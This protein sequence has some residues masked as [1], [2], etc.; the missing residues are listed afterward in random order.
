MLMLCVFHMC[1]PKH[2]MT[3]GWRL[4]RFLHTINMRSH[5]YAAAPLMNESN[6]CID[7]IYARHMHAHTYVA[8]SLLLTWT[9][10][11]FSGMYH[12]NTHAYASYIITNVAIVILCRSHAHTHA[13]S[14]MITNMTLSWISLTPIHALTYVCAAAS[15]M[16]ALLEVA[17]TGLCYWHSESA[18][19][20]ASLNI[21]KV[22]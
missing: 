18:A 12:A 6:S 8:I 22:R 3:S 2:A 4:H 7:S 20:D 16:D 17:W 9:W 11:R 15:L 5:A 14:Q 21:I 19:V 10:D 1:T 13:C